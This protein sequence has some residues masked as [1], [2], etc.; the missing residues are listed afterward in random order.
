MDKRVVLV[1]EEMPDDCHGCKLKAITEDD[2]EYCPYIRNYAPRIGRANRCPLLPID[3][4]LEQ[5]RG[6]QDG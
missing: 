5:E 2:N 3:K 1:M 6:R 4:F